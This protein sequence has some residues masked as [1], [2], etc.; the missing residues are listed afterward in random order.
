[1][2][3]ICSGLKPK[4]QYLSLEKEKETFC[5]VFT[6]SIKRAREVRKFRVAVVQRW[7][8]MYKKSVMHVQSC[9]FTNINLL[10]FLP[11]SLRSLLS[12]P[13]VPFVVIQKFCYHGN[14]TSH[15]SSLFRQVNSSGES[16][17]S[18]K[19]GGGGEGGG[20][21]HPDPEIRR[22]RFFFF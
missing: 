12:L 15:F 8:K 2:L 22:G 10:L 13:N 19:G 4:G 21:G 6:Y 17:P 9:C 3:V 14:L 7:L 1:M 18:Y 16:R 11:L 5:V 20:G